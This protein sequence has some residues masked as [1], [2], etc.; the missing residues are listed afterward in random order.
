MGPSPSTSDLY[1]AHHGAGYGS[2]INA[3]QTAVIIDITDVMT[4]AR[5]FACVRSI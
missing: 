4:C 5:Q 3:L 2:A 1:N